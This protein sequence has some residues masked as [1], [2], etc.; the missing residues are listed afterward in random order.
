MAWLRHRGDA[1]KQE[2]GV[3][4]GLIKFMGLLLLTTLLFL[5]GQSMVRHHFF[6]GG[7]QNYHD[8]PTG[9]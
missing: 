6:S 8:S 4:L 7:A 3:W 9:P 5:L 2:P 1:E